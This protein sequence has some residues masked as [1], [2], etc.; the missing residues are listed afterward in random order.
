MD[1]HVWSKAAEDSVGLKNYY[2]QHKQQYQWQPGVSALV[3]SSSSK[4]AD[5]FYCGC[6]KQNAKDWRL[7]LL[8]TMKWQQQTAAGSKMD[9]YH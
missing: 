8:L 4:D 9:N 7:S 5:R 6:T 1:K 3:V 2:N